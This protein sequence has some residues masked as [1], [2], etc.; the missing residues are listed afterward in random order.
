[1]LPG[2][3]GRGRIGSEMA[4]PE[5]TA[6]F[7]EAKPI[8]ATDPFRHFNLTQVFQPDVADEI[9]A[10]LE[11]TNKW[12][13]RSEEH[14]QAD[15]FVLRPTELP[16]SMSA[17]FRPHNL[18]HLRQ[19][20]ADAYDR[21]FADRLRIEAFRHGPGGETSVHNDHAKNEG[22]FT[23]RLVIYLT[24][25]WEPDM[26]GRL[27]LFRMAEGRAILEREYD[28]LHNSA[29]SMEFG[30]TSLHQV[31]TVVSGFRYSLVISFATAMA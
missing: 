9:L 12:V 16:A 18:E 14:W 19:V 7:A 13:N 31:E 15:A 29:N 4:E 21:K 22:A 1:M 28:P 26:G 27:R 5:I 30:P 23:H 11:S 24:R 8:V 2:H 10:W 20:L 25:A 3:S 6:I 17:V